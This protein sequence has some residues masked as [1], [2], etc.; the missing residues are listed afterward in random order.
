MSV[1]CTAVGTERRDGLSV[2][3]DVV[4]SD[5]VADDVDVL[6]PV[7]EQ[8][9]RT[10]AWCRGGLSLGLAGALAACLPV[11]G[12]VSASSGHDAHLQSWS[13]V[14]CSRSLELALTAAAGSGG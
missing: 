7:S 9:L 4:T 14:S 1:R 11:Q 6:K 3:V 2:A 5:V 10:P 13:G 8:V 12:V